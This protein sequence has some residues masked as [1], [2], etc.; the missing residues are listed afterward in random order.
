MKRILYFLNHIYQIL[1]HQIHS[2]FI[3]Q[4][5]VFSWREWL[6]ETYTIAGAK[7]CKVSSRYEA[8]VP[9]SYA[10]GQGQLSDLQASTPSTN[11]ELHP[12]YTQESSTTLNLDLT[13]DEPFSSW[14]I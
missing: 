1:K 4:C 6:L 3:K 11:H 10:I 8:K 5:I 7:G 14:N 2:N 13:S 9:F 12:L